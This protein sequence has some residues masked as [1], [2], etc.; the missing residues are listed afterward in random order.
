MREIKNKKK[1][2]SKL[3]IDILNCKIKIK[4]EIKIDS[5]IKTHNELVNL[6]WLNCH[7]SNKRKSPRP[8]EN[9]SNQFFKAIDFKMNLIFKSFIE[10]HNQIE[11]KECYQSI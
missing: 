8:L 5:N 2:L 1:V 4:T 9:I 7:S 6:N 3:Q 11:F 10:L